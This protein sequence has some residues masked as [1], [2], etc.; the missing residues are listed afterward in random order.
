MFKFFQNK[1]IKKYDIRKEIGRGAYGVASLAKS[2]ADN[3]EVVIK[4][5]ITYCLPVCNKS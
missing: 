5:N 2:K 1:G 4:V 3:T